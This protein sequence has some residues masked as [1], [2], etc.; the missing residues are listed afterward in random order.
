MGLRKLVEDALRIKIVRNDKE[1]DGIPITKNK[2][3]LAQRQIEQA[4]SGSLLDSEAIQKFRT[5]SN[6]R[7]EKYAEYEEMLSDATIAASIEMYA[8]DSTQYNFRTGKIL[9]VE[10][11]DADIAAAGNRLIDVLNLNEKA[12][13]H[14][15]SLCT[16]GDLYLRIYRDGDSSDYSDLLNGG[17][18]KTEIKTK[19]QDESRHME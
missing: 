15:Y 3:D 9:W 17:G 2:E 19:V 10:S 18:G 6:N 11:E 7:Q 4:D 1:F 5:L 12:W 13:R 16:Y 8:D 14:I